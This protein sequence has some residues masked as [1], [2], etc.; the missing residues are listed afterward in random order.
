MNL[1]CH[2][3][4]GSN[5]LPTRKILNGVF[6]MVLACFFHS[7]LVIAQ[8]GR[9]ELHT[10]DSLTLTDQEFLQGKNDG[11]PV[12]LSAELRLPR[13]KLKSYPA[14]V[15]I[16]GSGGISGYVDDWANEISTMGVAVYLVDS[17]TA[18]GLY[19]VNNDQSKLGRLAMIVDA[20]RA[21]DQLAQDKRID[22]KRIALMGFSRGG[23]VTLYSSMKRFYSMHGP[24]AGHEFAAYLAF[25]PACN[26]HYREDEL[27]VD[28]PIRIFHGSA[29]NYNPVAPCRNYIDRLRKNGKDVVLHEYTGAYHVFDY[30]KL[31][32]PVV[33]KKAQ[34]TRSCRMEESSNG[35]ILNSETKQQ[36]TYD[37]PCVEH[38]PTMAFNQSA[39]EKSRQELR[40]FI[41]AIL[42]HQKTDLSLR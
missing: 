26:T 4:I 6:L 37:D 8:V 7:S 19:K 39:Y 3:Y 24:K 15:L 31:V 33:L 13:K 23:Q 27:V 1:T 41:G 16:H 17:F 42:I 34:T 36:F 40:N 30:K 38:G 35:I 14:V 20:Y 32:K 5:F 2:N 12:K 28:K 11:K 29:D 22:S 21:L 25:Y 9:I 18:R 10:F